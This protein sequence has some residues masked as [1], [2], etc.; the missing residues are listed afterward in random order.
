MFYETFVRS[1][2]DYSGKELKSLV[3]LSML[4]LH[5]L[6]TNPFGK[7]YETYKKNSKQPCISCTIQFNF[8]FD[9]TVEDKHI[10]SIAKNLFVEQVA[11]QSN[12]M[13]KKINQQSA[14]VFFPI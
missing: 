7:I 9:I 14:S 8:M 5:E 4:K 13:I 12:L 3:E 6:F 2:E 11:F 1:L 10:H